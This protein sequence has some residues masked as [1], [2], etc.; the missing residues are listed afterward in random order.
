MSQFEQ[1]EKVRFCQKLGESASKTFQMVKQAYNEEVLGCSDVF[2]WHKHSAQG[3]DSLADEEHTSQPRMVRTELK[4]QEAA[5]L[6]GANR[7]QTADEITAA[8]AA[9]AA[10]GISHSTYHRILSDDLNMS[11]VTQQCSMCPD[12]RPT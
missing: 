11:H 2:K 4:I 10:A 3:K 1:W 9:A 5:T 6:V 7:S 12:A 8:A